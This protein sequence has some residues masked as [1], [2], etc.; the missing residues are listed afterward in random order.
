VRIKQDVA[1][2]VMKG[3]AFDFTF[4]FTFDIT[5]EIKFYKGPH[6]GSGSLGALWKGVA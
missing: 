2:D 3:V 6:P 4:D 5:F 1:H